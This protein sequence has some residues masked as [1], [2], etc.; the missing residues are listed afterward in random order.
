MASAMGSVG[1]G[2]STSTIPT[3]LSRGMC[4][5]NG[6]M[7]IHVTSMS[8]VMDTTFPDSLTPKAI[9]AS[10]MNIMEDRGYGSVRGNL[11]RGGFSGA[12]NAMN[13]GY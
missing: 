5:W 1:G 8:G 6:A 4:S 7:E 10:P 11:R 12:P 3:R 13:M 9:T 2:V